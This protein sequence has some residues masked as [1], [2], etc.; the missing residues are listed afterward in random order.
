MKYKFGVHTRNSMQMANIVSRREELIYRV[1]SEAMK[2]LQVYFVYKLSLTIGVQ[3]G[4]YSSL[5]LCFRKAEL[6]YGQSFSNL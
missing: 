5:R 1:K 4:A 2:A 3:K 6:F